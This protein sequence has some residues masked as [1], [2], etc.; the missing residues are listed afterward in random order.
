MTVERIEDIVSS[1]D[2]GLVDAQ[3]A[4]R[5]AEVVA[6][7]GWIVVTRHDPR[8]GAEFYLNASTIIM[9]ERVGKDRGSIVE[10]HTDT[11]RTR[12]TPAQIAALIARA[13]Q[14]AQP[15]APPRDD[16]ALLRHARAIRNV[17]ANAEWGTPEGAEIILQYLICD[18]AVP[19]TD[20]LAR[21]EGRAP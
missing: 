1:Y 9:F 7:P 14:P 19:L 21:H 20:A 13:Q 17:L 16:V 6:P 10:T 3:P 5:D 11:L 2:A 18:H 8:E 15:V 4:A 12:E